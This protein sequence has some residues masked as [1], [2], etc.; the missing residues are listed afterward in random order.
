[1]KTQKKIEILQKMIQINSVN[2]NETQVADYIS[3]L[4]SPYPDVDIQKI[5]YAP[6]R[7]NLVLTIGKNKGPILGLSGHMDVV[8]PG[9]RADWNYD[10][11]AAV[12]ADHKIYGR[13]ATDMKSGLAALVVTLLEL[14]EQKVDLPGKLRLLATVGEE[15]G[16]YGA[17]QL[18]KQGFAD[19]LAGLIVAEP[20]SRMQKIVYTARGV[21]DY[22]V[23]SYGK[24]AHSAE[25]QHGINAI[26]NLIVFYHLALERLLKFTETDAVL[27]GVTHSI[28]KIKGGEQVNSI[29]SYAELM[30][31]IR[32]IPAYPNQYFYDELESI[33]A[34]LNQ[35]EGF[36]LAIA[37]SFPEE[38]IAGNPDS[39]IIQL[40]Q[41][42]HLQVLGSVAKVTGSSGANDGAEFLQAK[43][44]FDSIEIG[45]GSATSHQSN[46]YV[47]IDD[48][49]NAI[50]FYKQ[51]ALDFLK[52]KQIQT[53]Y[54]GID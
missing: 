13:G 9:N 25:P 39:R 43:G 26:D 11:F 28:T 17:A 8:A 52:D 50:N 27:G 1:M 35:K 44:H 14:L 41:K 19:N 42:T 20:T 51:F 37:Y 53:D 30:G 46:E 32:T 5:N 36:K 7:D 16:E 48:Y 15:T 33:I 10:P 18:T 54:T 12:I 2:N 29:P 40:A 45:P 34:E 6:N 47:E 31:N 3:S 49:L 22:K 4:F 23:I 38:A 24:A 21:I